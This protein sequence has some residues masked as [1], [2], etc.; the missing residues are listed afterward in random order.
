MQDYTRNR[1]VL[2]FAGKNP[3]RTALS[4]GEM[5]PLSRKLKTFWANPSASVKAKIRNF[6]PDL[7]RTIGRQI[8]RS[9]GVAD[10]LSV[11]QCN[12][13]S[14]SAALDFGDLWFLYAQ[15]RERR[16]AVILEFGSGASTVVLA[17]AVF[18]NTVGHVYSVEGD[19]RWAQST[20]ECMP[21]HLRTLCTVRYCPVRKVPY[22]NSLWGLTHVNL[23]AV[24]PN[25][26]YLDGPEGVGLRRPAIDLL[27]LE[28]RRFYWSILRDG[29]VSPRD[30]CLLN[31]PSS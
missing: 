5:A 1:G 16:P 26:V 6:V 31:L 11:F 19:P 8:L 10:A 13:P 17:Q 24:I 28:I 29:T 2:R 23:P 22:S 30:G 9:R 4:G 15:A 14:E 12:R 3:D 7:R 27:E 20:T 21:K 25:M 18:D